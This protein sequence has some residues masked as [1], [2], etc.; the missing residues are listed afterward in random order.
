MFLQHGQWGGAKI[1][2]F[3]KRRGRIQQSFRAT[4]NVKL[5]DFKWEIYEKKTCILTRKIFMYNDYLH[6]RITVKL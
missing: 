1:K 2:K 3:E 5:Q 4:K 6:H